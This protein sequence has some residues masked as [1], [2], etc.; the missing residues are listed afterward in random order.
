MQTL[1]YKPLHHCL[2]AFDDYTGMD[3]MI[4]LKAPSKQ[5]M[6]FRYLGL[7]SAICTQQKEEAGLDNG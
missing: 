7:C 1:F 4:Y 3:I 6:C 2:C 5:Q